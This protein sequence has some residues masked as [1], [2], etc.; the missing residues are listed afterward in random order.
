MYC[1]I[2]PAQSFWLVC[3]G[4]AI[5]H[6][7][8]TQW[9]PHVYYL[10]FVHELIGCSC[11]NIIN[12]AIYTPIPVPSKTFSTLGGLELSLNCAI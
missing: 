4:E 3:M 9:G 2:V 8:V 7:W 12:P 1:W 5:L 11:V 6:S 10:A